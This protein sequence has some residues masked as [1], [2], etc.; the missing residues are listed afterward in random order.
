MATTT[1]RECVKKAISF[2]YPGRI[3]LC[4]DF[5]S[6]PLNSRILD[7]AMKDIP[8]VQTDILVVKCSDPL[9]F[10]AEEGLTEW[11]YRWDSMGETMGEVTDPPHQGLGHA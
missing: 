8:T 6:D 3:P 5:D 11:G 9:F 2:Q 10:P 4:V 7:E 1:P